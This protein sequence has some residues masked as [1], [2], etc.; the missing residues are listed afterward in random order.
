MAAYPYFLFVGERPSPR[1]IAI[2]ATWQNGG[3][4]AKTLHDA[5][6][7]VGI[8]PLR[9]QYTNLWCP[10]GM[11]HDAQIWSIAAHAKTNGTVVAL[12]QKVQKALEQR[13][14]PFVAMRHPA[15]RGADRKR[16]R[17]IAHVRAA[18]GPFVTEADS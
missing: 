16:E 8:D 7:E 2:G 17:Y 9:H 3:L 18:L 10:D 15:A 1:A 11:L 14:I 12:G 13:G 4:C 5:L 6:R